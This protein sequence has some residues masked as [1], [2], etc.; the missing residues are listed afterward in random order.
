VVTTWLEG[1]PP[2]GERDWR[3]VA[4]ELAR[5]HRFTA[6]RAQRPGFAS[7]RD[8]LEVERGGD[9]DLSR[10]PAEAVALCRAAWSALA[11][12]PAAVVHGDPGPQNLRLRG[13]RVGLLDWDESRVDCPEL[14]LA[15]L[16][17]D[18]LGPRRQPARTAAEAWEVANGWTVEP[19]HAHRRLAELRRRLGPAPDA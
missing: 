6:G 7:T 12:V 5:L 15:W 19:D 8:L 4:D 11:C 13:D 17:V 10:M 14:D 2:A 1:D 9:V 3:L 18:R 16:P